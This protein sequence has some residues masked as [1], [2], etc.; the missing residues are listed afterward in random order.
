[1]LHLLTLVPNES[2]GFSGG[3]TEG[4]GLLRLPVAPKAQRIH[5]AISNIYGPLYAALVEA[6]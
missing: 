6:E 4:F 2:E 5:F 3:A 1:M